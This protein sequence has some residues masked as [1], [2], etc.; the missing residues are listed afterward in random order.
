M[1]HPISQAPLRESLSSNIFAT[2]WPKWF[3]SISAYSAQ[4]TE[5]QP[6]INPAAV[7][8]NATSEQTFTVTG[9]KADD[10]VL[11]INKPT[12]TSGVGIVGYRVSADDTIA[13]TFMN[14]TAGSVDPPSETYKVIILRG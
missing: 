7:G 12:H 13:I 9:V 3:N 8:A 11:T 4:L 5:F 1:K 6:T 10:V 14:T 2:G